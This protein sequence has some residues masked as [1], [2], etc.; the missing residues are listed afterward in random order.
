[1]RAFSGEV[2]APSNTSI[3]QPEAAAHPLSAN[4]PHA[5]AF[6]NALVQTAGEWSYSIYLWLSAAPARSRPPCFNFWTT[7][8]GS[9]AG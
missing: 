1:M 2:R 5:A 4:R 3:G 6:K 7:P 9:T 8:P